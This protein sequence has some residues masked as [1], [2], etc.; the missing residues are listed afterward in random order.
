M[1]K[2]KRIGAVACAIALSVCGLF[3]LPQIAQAQNASRNSTLCHFT[4]GPRAGETQ[5][6]APMAALPVGTP[7]Q[8]GQGSNGRVVAKSQRNGDDDNSDISDHSSRPSGKS[9]LCHFTS[10][11]RAGETQDYA[12][13]AALPVG[14]PCQDGQGSNGRV[15][16]KSQRNGD[17]D[18][19]DISDHSSRPSGKSTLCHFTSGPRAGETQDYA[20]MAALPVG[21]PCQDGQ[22]SNGRVVARNLH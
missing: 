1:F 8:D 6:Y 15:V 10:G 18:N 20:P 7:C 16:A 17:D 9:T 5:D 4:S 2:S 11:P 3:A 14:T 13:M 12:P 19:S 21:T 22:G